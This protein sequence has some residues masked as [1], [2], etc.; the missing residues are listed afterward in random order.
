MGCGWNDCGCST[1]YTDA[2][3]NP[4]NT[5][6]G[7]TS[8]GSATCS[9]DWSLIAMGIGAAILGLLMASGGKKR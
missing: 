6:D 5:G 3:G 8:D 1:V 9:P 4:I 2:W 7:G